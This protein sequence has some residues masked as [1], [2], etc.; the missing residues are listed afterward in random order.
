MLIISSVYITFLNIYIDFFFRVLISLLNLYSHSDNL[1]IFGI[2]FICF[3]I[4]IYEN[5]CYVWISGC[6]PKTLY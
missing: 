3:D 2:L 6:L 4:H 1:I 5:I